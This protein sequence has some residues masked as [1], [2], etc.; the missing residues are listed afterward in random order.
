MA[1]AI[2]RAVG[3]LIIF[4]ISNNEVELALLQGTADQYLGGIGGKL[5]VIARRCRVGVYKLCTA[6]IF[7][8]QLINRGAGFKLAI[9]VIGDGERDLVFTGIVGDAAEVV[10]SHLTDDVGLFAYSIKRKGQ[11][12]NRAVCGVLGGTDKSRAIGFIQIEREF[13]LL[14]FTRADFNVQRLVSGQSNINAGGRIGVGKGCGCSVNRR[15]FVSALPAYI[16]LS[17]ANQL[18]IA[19]IL[20]R[21]H[22]LINGGVVGDARNG[23]GVLADEVNVIFCGVEYQRIVSA[24][25]GGLILLVDGSGT[26][27]KSRHGGIAITAQGEGEGIRIVPVAA[28]QH[29]CHLEQVFGVSRERMCIVGVYKLGFAV[30]VGIAVINLGFQVVGGGIQRNRDGGGDI[31]GI[32]HAIGGGT[33][34]LDGI[35]VNTR[36]C[37]GDCTEIGGLIAF[38]CR[39]GFAALISG[40]RGTD[41]CRKFKGERI[42]TIPVTAGNALAYAQLSRGCTCK[43]VGEGQFVGVYGFP[44]GFRCIPPVVGGRDFQQFT[45]CCVCCVGRNL[46]LNQIL[47]C[48]VI[49][50]GLMLIHFG[51]L[52]IIDLTTVFAQRVG[53]RCKGNLTVCIVDGACR[54]DRHGGVVARQWR[55]LL[56]HR[57]R[58]ELEVELT[59]SQLHPIAILVLVD[60]RCLNVKFL[61]FICKDVCKL[62]NCRICGGVITEYLLNSG[63]IHCQLASAIIHDGN[64]HTVEGAV[65]RNAGDFVSGDNLGDVVLISAGFREGDTS[66][67]KVDSRS[68]GASLT[69]HRVLSIAYAIRFS[70]FFGQRGASDSLQL[71]GKGIAAPPIAALQN[72]FSP[73]RIIGVVVIRVYRNFLRGI[74]VGHRNG[75][76]LGRDRAGAVINALL[77]IAFGQLFFRLRDSIGAAYGQAHN[78]GSLAVFQGKFTVVL[79]GTSGCLSA[80]SFGNGVVIRGIGVHALACQRKLHRKGGVSARVQAFVGFNHLGNLHAAG[81]IHGQLTVVAKVQHTPVRGK[82]PLEVNAA[83]GGAGQV[84]VNGTGTGLV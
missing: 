20:D 66:E 32:G 45:C 64:G 11:E 4:L 15:V 69:R 63:G 16:V 36:L 44:L 41:F 70:S 68:V 38:G 49:N 31:L 47:L 74:G 52:V 33:C 14:Q 65:I 73:E 18:A 42:F 82:V 39:C 84:T 62:G 29:L 48:A 9:T 25:G 23:T 54:V 28:S 43:F 79:D 2:V 13:V 19:I 37:V 46:N 17:I 27:A 34:F 60:F 53:N 81:G 21:Y 40:H 30:G 76:G 10:V 58:F 83:F 77:G 71:E 26:V 56:V 24:E 57:C 5:D 51:K 80:I 72:L 35:V 7:V 6:N 55:I 78:L 12:C 61:F 1:F 22:D 67:V 8:V 59:F 75:R 3:N 50:I